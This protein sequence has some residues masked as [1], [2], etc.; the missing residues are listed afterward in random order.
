MT[1]AVVIVAGGSGLR[2]GGEK[3]KQYQLVGGKPLI[4]WTIHAFASHPGV[5]H[6]QVVIGD[7]HDEMFAE[8]TGRTCQFCHRSLVAPP[9]RNSC[10]RGL[11][12]LERLAPDKVIIH[13][14]AR[15]FASRDLISHVIAWLDRHPAVLPGL[16]VAE[17]LKKAPGGQ[18][19]ATVDRTS[20]WTAQTPQGFHFAPILAAHRKAWAEGIDTLTDDAAVAEHAG[21]AVTMIPGRERKPQGRPPP[22]MWITPTGCSPPGRSPNLPDIRVGQGFD[23]HPFTE[24]SA[25]TLCGVKIPFDKKLAG[26]S[27]A[28]VAMHALTDAILGAIGEGD[29]GVHFPP[30]EPRWKGAASSIFLAKAVGLVRARGGMIANADISIIAEAPKISP[31]LAAM[32]RVLSRRTRAYRSIASPS[33]PRRPRNSAHWDGA[34]ASP[35]WLSHWSAAVSLFS[36]DLL[37]DAEGSARPV[38][39]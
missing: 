11:E 32:K 20:M 14:A 16:P 37:R 36:P 1:V 24:G 9:A 28:D 33:R 5:S 7:D 39:R 29:I 12:A 4:W 2:A 31:H 38:P 3:P 13:D 26:H 27:D 22:R 15:P 34:K 10:R 17:T 23:I 8:A 21:I 6:V 25:V 30:S 35:P 19:V 18:V